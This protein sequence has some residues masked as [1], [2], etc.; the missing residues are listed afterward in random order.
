MQRNMGLFIFR[1]HKHRKYYIG[2][3]WGY[4]DDGYICSSNWMAMLKK[5]RRRFEA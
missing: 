5:R 2:C 3:H 4:E 1:E